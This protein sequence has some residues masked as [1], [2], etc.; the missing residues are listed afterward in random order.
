MRERSH[1]P[2]LPPKGELSPAPVPPPRRNKR[3]GRKEGLS[4]MQQVKIKF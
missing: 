1:E 3:F 2:P 4:S